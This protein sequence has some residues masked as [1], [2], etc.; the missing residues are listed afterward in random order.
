V[1]INAVYFKGL[2]ATPFKESNTYK[3]VFH[4]SKGTQNVMMM[5]DKREFEYRE[6]SR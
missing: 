4:S 5:Q 6:T 2:F 3:D 1:L